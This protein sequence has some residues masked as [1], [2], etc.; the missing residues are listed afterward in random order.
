M[1]PKSC[2][3][4]L[5]VQEIFLEFQTIWSGEFTKL[6]FSTLHQ[7]QDPAMPAI[8]SAPSLPGTKLEDAKQIPSHAGKEI[9]RYVRNIGISLS[10]DLRLP[11]AQSNVTSSD[12]NFGSGLI[13][14]DSSQGNNEQHHRVLWV[15]YCVL[16][17]FHAFVCISVRLL[18][19]SIRSAAVN[20]D[21]CDTMCFEAFE[22]K[23]LYEFYT[24]LYTKCW[25]LNC[26]S[27][28]A[29]V[30]LTGRHMH[31]REAWKQSTS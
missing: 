22:E 20:K 25:H 10:T 5:S 21:L 4:S 2:R 16:C 15:C 24:F 19:C 6:L 23:T 3:D 31:E 12:F 18:V 27:H 26:G 28:G 14:R 29:M 7:H 30:C 11:E 17:L 1:N 8:R 9:Q 13:N